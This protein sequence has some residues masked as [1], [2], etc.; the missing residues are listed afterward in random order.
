[1]HIIDFK[2]SD[3]RTQED[4]DKKVKEN[5]QLGIY[6]LAWKELFG[7]LPDS[8]E[9]HFLETGII[10]TAHKTEQDI[11]KVWEKIQKVADGL[12]KG[13]YEAKPSPVICGYCPYNE[14]C[15]ESAV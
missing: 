1:V 5:L 6:A 15:P 13:R 7:K 14:L 11:A 9:L 8:V 10:G 2:S 4:A 3:V 12:R